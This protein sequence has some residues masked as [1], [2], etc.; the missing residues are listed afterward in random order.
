VTDP[1]RDL[2]YDT[3][4]GMLHGGPDYGIAQGK[5]MHWLTLRVQHTD[6]GTQPAR[7]TARSPRLFTARVTC[8]RPVPQVRRQAPPS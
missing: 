8:P 4:V 3:S 2:L 7:V 1:N 6:E 5:F